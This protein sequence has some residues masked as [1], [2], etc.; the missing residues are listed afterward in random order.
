[1]ASDSTLKQYTP[2]SSARCI[3]AACLPTPENTTLCGSP[4]AAKTRSNSPRLTI[5]KPAPKRASTFNTAKFEFDFTAKQT[6]FGQSPSAFLNSKKR[7]SKAFLEYTY[8][9]V[10][11][12]SAS[13][14]NETC[15]ANRV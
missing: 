4:P 1:S 10:P 8:K 12:C 11:Y 14:A 9:G 6:K 3:S 15:S 7:S 5:S 13:C 2:T